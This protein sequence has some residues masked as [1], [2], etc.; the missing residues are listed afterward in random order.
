MGPRA[1]TAVPGL[2]KLGD[3]M[4]QRPVVLQAQGPLQPTA[5]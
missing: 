5:A 1:S 4:I 3:R 2:S